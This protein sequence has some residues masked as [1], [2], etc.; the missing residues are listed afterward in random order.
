M[1]VVS[2]VP[3]TL[4]DILQGLIVLFVLLGLSFQFTRRKKAE[5]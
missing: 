3:I 4:V 5:V 1:Q 2:G